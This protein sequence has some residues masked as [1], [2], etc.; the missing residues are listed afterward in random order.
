MH[1]FKLACILKNTY[2]RH[3]TQT[4][5]FLVLIWL[6]WLRCWIFLDRHLCWSC[7]W[8]PTPMAHWIIIVSAGEITVS[9]CNARPREPN[10]LWLWCLKWFC[11]GFL[12]PWCSDKP[13]C[14]SLVFSRMMIKHAY[15]SSKGKPAILSFDCLLTL[16]VPNQFNFGQHVQNSL[17]LGLWT[18]TE[19][20]PCCGKQLFGGKFFKSALISIRIWY[21][22]WF[23]SIFIG[24]PRILQWCI[25]QANVFLLGLLKQEWL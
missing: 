1:W 15:F 3:Y 22:I 7:L 18:G 10:Q 2:Q 5:L 14:I 4:W 6:C 20:I 25:C 11:S 24:F 9:K 8:L 13:S 19:P 16:W 12:E 21:D 23:L 17:K